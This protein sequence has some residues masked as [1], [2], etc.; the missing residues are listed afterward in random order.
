MA[1]FV[2]GPIPTHEDPTIQSL[3]RI[4]WDLFISLEGDVTQLTLTEIHTAPQN[5]QNGQIW[6]AD[7]TD[8]NPGSG[9]GVY[10]F[11]GSAFVFLG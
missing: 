2:A 9:R 3:L 4:I 11:K 7:G 5:P 10:I 6:Y 1:H 8:W